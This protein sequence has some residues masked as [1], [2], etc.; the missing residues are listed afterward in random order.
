MA[1]IIREKMEKGKDRS[2]IFTKGKEITKIGELM[3]KEHR[4]VIKMRCARQEDDNGRI[5]Y[6]LVPDM[7]CN[8]HGFATVLRSLN[9]NTGEISQDTV[10]I[11]EEEDTG[12]MF[13]AGLDEFL[14]LSTEEADKMRKQLREESKNVKKR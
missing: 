11:L 10:A 8:Y 9:I 3:D 5:N 7:V 4:K 14:F 1:G 6:V 13:V 2:G 12:M